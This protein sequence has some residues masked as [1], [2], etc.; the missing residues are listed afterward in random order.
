MRGVLWSHLI[1]CIGHRRAKFFEL[2]PAEWQKRRAPIPVS[3]CVAF[4]RQQVVWLALIY[5]LAWKCFGSPRL[6]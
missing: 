2:R 4:H 3:F 5:R 1:F 6:I